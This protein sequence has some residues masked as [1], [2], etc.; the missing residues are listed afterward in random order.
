MHLLPIRTSRSDALPSQL[1]NQTIPSLSI[2]TVAR[3]LLASDMPETRW[4]LLRNRFA[5]WSTYQYPIES[6]ELPVFDFTGLIPEEDIAYYAVFSCLAE[7]GPSLSSDE[8]LK[9]SSTQELTSGNYLV[10]GEK[11][12][13]FAMSAT[14][15]GM[16][17]CKPMVIS[18]LTLRIRSYGILQ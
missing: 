4:S 16:P 3:M 5:G 7:Q 6:T 8:Y 14:F 1:W 2:A 10:V 11:D 9:I 13:L 15:T 17:W 12:G 18:S